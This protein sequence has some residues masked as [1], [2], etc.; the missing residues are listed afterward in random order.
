MSSLALPQAYICDLA[1]YQPGQPIAA[2]A[3]EYGLEPA[4]IIKLASNENPLGMGPKAKAAIRSTVRELHRYPEQYGLL[5][6][7]AAHLGVHS[8]Q[9]VLGNGS[10]DVLDIVARTFIGQENEAVSSQYAFAIY[11]LATQAVG[12]KNVIVPAAAYGH[13]LSAMAQA[14]T[15]ATRVIWIANPNNPTG[16]F[17]PYKDLRA[18]MAQVPRQIIVVLDE[19]YYEY[20]TPES[21]GDA[22][23]WIAKH[24]NLVV[25]R[26]FS[27]IYGLAG[28]RIGY[29][30]ASP[31][32]AG[33]L[34]RVR[35]PF[36]AN[37]AALAAAEAALDD[38]A[39]LQRSY[40]ANRRGR[41][42]LTAGLAKLGLECL[43]AYGNFV[44]FC[45]PDA[46]ALNNALLG[47]GI[48][49]RPLAG[50]G[51]PGFIRVTIGT[52]TQNVRFL[53][54]MA[55]WYSGTHD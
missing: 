3:R 21:R 52:R 12:G 24:P 26:T 7:L 53:Q 19:A 5:Q 46:A 42:Q 39:F 36:N 32:V 44:T 22:I 33:L 37:S 17:V 28:L 49:V 31:E 27:K 38:T 55:K 30:V 11:Q 48:I 43:P 35:Q 20:L 13:D 50:Y 6:K 10:N 18:F 1:P 2:V 34:N 45:A 15:S 14:I 51:M 40:E 9:L 47:Q 29:G 23:S 41:L 16:T 25:I 54:A 4:A 8:S